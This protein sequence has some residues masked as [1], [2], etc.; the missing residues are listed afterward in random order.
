MA[1]RNHEQLILK[2]RI[3]GTLIRDARIAS[4]RSVTDASLL[5]GVEERAYLAFEAGQQAPSLPQLEV[6]A[7]FYNVPLSHFWDSKTLAAKSA[8]DPVKSRVPEVLM[9]RQR[10]IGVRVRQIR[11]QRGYTIEQVAEATGHEPRQIAN[12]ERG[13][14]TLP[15]HELELVASAIGARLDELIDRHGPVGNW[16]STQ[17]EFDKFADLPA[18]LRQFILKPINRSYLELAMRM[19][20]MQVDRL[21]TIAESILEIT[22]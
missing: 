19:S 4:G 21:R 17:E 13:V 3:V 16:L 14:S 6:L 10:I 20:E 5:L 1:T 18:D 11:E 9:L 8:E 2:N 22:Y 7:Y 15:L 12:V